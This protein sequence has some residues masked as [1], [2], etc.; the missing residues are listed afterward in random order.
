M[1]ASSDEQAT[2]IDVDKRQSSVRPSAQSHI[3]A[4]KKRKKRDTIDSLFDSNNMY[5]QVSFFVI[6]GLTM[7]A[8]DFSRFLPGFFTY[9]V[10]LFGV[11]RIFLKESRPFLMSSLRV[12][13]CLHICHCLSGKQKIFTAKIL[14]VFLKQWHHLFFRY[15]SYFF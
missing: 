5:Y 4:R 6:Y 3:K 1:E 15:L 12:K 13:T 11:L 9:Y 7:I 14:V 10:A 2:V 8:L